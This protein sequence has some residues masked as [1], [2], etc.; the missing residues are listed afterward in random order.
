MVRTLGSART[1]LF[2]VNVLFYS[3]HAFSYYDVS[4]EARSS[5]NI[6]KLLF[7]EILAVRNY[8]TLTYQK[9]E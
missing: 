1:W 7:S 3:F 2:L 6:A 5:E 4:R 9:L 8:A